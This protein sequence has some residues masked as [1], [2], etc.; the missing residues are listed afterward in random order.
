MVSVFMFQVHGDFTNVHESAVTKM[1]VTQVP[2]IIKHWNLEYL[3]K[4]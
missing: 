1:V 3:Q 2:T 4:L